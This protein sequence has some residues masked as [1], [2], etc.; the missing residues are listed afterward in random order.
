MRWTQTIV[1]ITPEMSQ[2]Q[3]TEAGTAGSVAER[4]RE[5]GVCV[6][7]GHI[8]GDPSHSFPYTPAVPYLLFHTCC[9]TPAVPYLRLLKQRL[10][11]LVWESAL[12]KMILCYVTVSSEWRVLTNTPGYSQLAPRFSAPVGYFWPLL[13]P[14]LSFLLSLSFPSF[15]S[16]LSLSTP[17]H[18]SLSLSLSLVSPS[19]SV[20]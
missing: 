6:L 19:F 7:E 1:N 11:S 10:S 15:S 3:S 2:V 14:P 9:S 5:I 16:P 13:Q 12:I 18:L 17:P 4:A 20:C 8:P